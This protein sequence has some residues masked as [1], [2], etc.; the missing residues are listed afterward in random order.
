MEIFSRL[1]E[2]SHEKTSNT[3]GGDGDM[4]GRPI[5]VSNLFES[6]SYL[7]RG[8]LLSRGSFDVVASSGRS[9]LYVK[10]P[11]IRT[12]AT[13]IFSTG[14]NQELVRV[15]NTSGLK[16]VFLSGKSI[17]EIKDARTTEVVGILQGRINVG[18]SRGGRMDWFILDPQGLEIG[19][20]E[21]RESPNAG[22]SDNPRFDMI[23]GSVNG[24]KVFEFK[25]NR[26]SFRFEMSVDF[27]M[28]IQNRLD[29]R[30]GLGIAVTLAGID[31]IEGD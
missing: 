13:R 27:S 24:S 17:F 2:R 6:D 31:R 7:I 30:L 21:E 5:E 23:L 29:R 10:G 12:S 14:G 19:R 11:G 22:S 20:I 28:D 26:E 3:I 9:V 16:D 8:R 18:L 25:I 15:D 4:L 1:E